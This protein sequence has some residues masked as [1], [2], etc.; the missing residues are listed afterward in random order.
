MFSF[1]FKKIRDKI[2]VR[3]L[4]I[5]MNH[6][7][8]KTKYLGS[9]KIEPWLKSA[10]C[11]WNS[12]L[13]AKEVLGISLGS[14]GWSA[15][16]GWENK[17]GTFDLNKWIKITNTPDAVPRQWDIVFWWTKFWKYGHVA[18]IDCANI[19]TMGT[20]SQNSTWA[21]WDKPGDEISFINYS[22]KGCL[23]WYRANAT[24][25]VATSINGALDEPLLAKIEARIPKAIGKIKP[26]KHKI[27]K[28]YDQQKDPYCT[29]FSSAGAWTYNHGKTFTNK[30]IYD[31]IH[32]ILKWNGGITT[33]IADKFAT[34]QGG[35]CLILTMFSPQSEL[36]LDAGYALVIS[37]RCPPEFWTDG[38]N[39]WVVNGKDYSPKTDGW[40]AIVLIKEGKKYKL[41][42]SWGN[43]ELLGKF[44]SY[45]I[46]AATLH[47]KGLIRTECSFIF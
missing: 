27:I 15:L 14:F 29:G 35:K 21:F 2:N 28:P 40:H 17:N 39:D 30:E 20:I 5:N 36:L 47:Q 46:D 12:K 7:E 11:V 42:N 18:I 23:G 19:N 32:P 33:R 41:I 16:S 26:N 3:F 37:T 13:Y 1:A 31:W 10:E 6:Q 25:S 43:Y 38:I 44:N 9:F 4:P 45:E 8:Y 24:P 34:L 22:Y